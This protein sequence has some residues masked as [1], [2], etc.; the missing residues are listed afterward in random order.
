MLAFYIASLNLNYMLGASLDPTNLPYGLIITCI[1]DS[2]NV[3]LGVVAPASINQCYNA[4]ML[5]G[6]GYIL[7][8]DA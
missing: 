6:M 7:V 5:G 2:C 1:L 3:S 4:T 8:E